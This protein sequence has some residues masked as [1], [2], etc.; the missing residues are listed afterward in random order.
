MYWRYAVF[1]NALSVRLTGSATTF[2]WFFKA[3]NTVS[4]SNTSLKKFS[5]K[6]RQFLLPQHTRSISHSFLCPTQPADTP[7]RT[8]HPQFEILAWVVIEPSF[9]KCHV[10]FTAKQPSISNIGQLVPCELRD[11]LLQKTPNDS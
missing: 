1:L 11:E 7:V 10:A 8:V 3:T 9:G 6:L 4:L 5:S 2:D